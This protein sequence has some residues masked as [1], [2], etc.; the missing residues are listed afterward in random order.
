MRIKTDHESFVA[1]V[2]KNG[3][4]GSYY[5]LFDTVKFFK[6]MHHLGKGKR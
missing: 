1:I 3:P 4:I 2:G 5:D 6:E